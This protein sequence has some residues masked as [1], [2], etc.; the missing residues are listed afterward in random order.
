MSE[1]LDLDQPFPFVLTEKS[2]LDHPIPFVPAEPL[3]F[4]TNFI[5]E[6]RAATAAE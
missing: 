1:I 3:E 2:D 4:C 6:E 5:F